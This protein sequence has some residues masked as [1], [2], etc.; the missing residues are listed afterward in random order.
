VQ[1]AGEAEKAELG[2]RG[3]L[4][5]A[6]IRFATSRDIIIVR[7]TAGPNED[8]PAKRCSGLR[9]SKILIRN[10]CALRHTDHDDAV[11]HALMAC[12]ASGCEVG[13]PLGKPFGIFRTDRLVEIR[14]RLLGDGSHH[15]LHRHIMLG[16]MSARKT[17]KG[18]FQI[19][20][21]VGGKIPVLVLHSDP[22][23]D[24]ARLNRRDHEI[25]DAW[26]IACSLR[27]RRSFRIRRVSFCPQPVRYK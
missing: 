27:C 14:E 10:R 6:W 19:P 5:M 22:E 23:P 15:V 3:R 9:R 17:G 24:V 16:R 2:H 8:Q 26:K 20:K 7:N 4:Q 12:I 25:A 18:A 21:F 13:I 11:I 1:A